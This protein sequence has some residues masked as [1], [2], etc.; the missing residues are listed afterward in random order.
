MDEKW[1]YACKTCSNCKVL[2]SIGMVPVDYY[3][4]HK[5]HVGKEMYIT[6]TAF[7]LNE[8]DISKGGT[9]IPISLLRVGKDGEYK[10]DTYH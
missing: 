3:V 2:T 8:N 5:S 1:F 6:V 9:A 7:A 10:K 4:H